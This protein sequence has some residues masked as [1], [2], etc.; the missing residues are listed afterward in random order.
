MALSKKASEKYLPEL[1]SACDIEAELTVPTDPVD[2]HAI[3]VGS[4]QVRNT[5]AE[6]IDSYFD[7]RGY[8]TFGL[9]GSLPQISEQRK[10]VCIGGG[11]ATFV[12]PRLGRTLERLTRLYRGEV[13]RGEAQHPS[14]AN[15]T[16]K[17]TL[18]GIRIDTRC[19]GTVWG[20]E[21]RARRCPCIRHLRSGHLPACRP[22]PA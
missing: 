12:I 20:P 5:I 19:T 14:D 9:P 16:V 3:D 7:D 4:A 15:G 18:R 6:G 22:R 1:P 11:G 21:L 2:Y 10:P 17:L 8:F 13:F